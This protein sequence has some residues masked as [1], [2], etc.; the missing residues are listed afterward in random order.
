[1]EVE[2]RNENAIDETEEN[3]PV[4]IFDR[5]EMRIRCRGQQNEHKLV[6]FSSQHY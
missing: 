4:N 1:L 2:D 6:I 5:N 3:V